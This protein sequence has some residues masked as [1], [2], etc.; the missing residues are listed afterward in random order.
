MNEYEPD[1]V[2]S[3]VDSNLY[4][5][6][7]SYVTYNVPLQYCNYLRLPGVKDCR[8]GYV[9]G[10]SVTEPRTGTLNATGHPVVVCTPSV[11]EPY[12]HMCPGPRDPCDSGTLISASSEEFL[13]S[14]V[15]ALLGR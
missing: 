4:P 6:P 2:P 15:R 9:S 10:E 3:R 1:R 14:D 8:C 11:L 12:E 13:L 5:T 7:G